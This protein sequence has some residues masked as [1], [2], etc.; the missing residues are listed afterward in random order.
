MQLKLD[1][2][3]KDL[4]KIF[5]NLMKIISIIVMKVNNHNNKN[6]NIKWGNMDIKIYI[7]VQ[8]F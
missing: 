3:Y 6:N 8:K 5:R 4:K 2:K 7:M 1:C